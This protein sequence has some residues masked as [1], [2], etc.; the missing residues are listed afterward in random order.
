MLKPFIKYLG[1]KR[2]LLPFLRPLFPKS[3]NTYY[4]C[5]LGGGAVLWD[6]SPKKAIISDLQ[7][8]LIDT[9]TVIKDNLPG[10][11]ESLRQHHHTNYETNQSNPGAYFYSVRAWDRV[12]GYENRPALEKAARYIFLNKTCFNGLMRQ[13][14]KGYL[15]SPWGKSLAQFEVD[16]VNLID[17]NSYLNNN[18]VEI[19]CTDGV[20]LIDKAGTDDL[21]FIDP[22]YIPVSDTS[23]FTAFSK[24]GF[25]MAD[26]L[27]LRNAI[28][29]ATD[30]GAKVIY[31]NADVPAVRELFN[32]PKYTLYPVQVRRAVNS[33]ASGRGKVGELVI[34]NYLP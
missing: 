6:I 19:L 34:L 18:E 16:E 17:C 30:R 20:P 32:D 24:D 27:R 2:S 13:N 21:L 4:E 15:N 8:D 22:P 29:R 28:D 3:F 11:L 25:N 31:C 33:V 14:S 5:F 9:Y 10:L 7:K 23:S 12:P 1:G 26:Q